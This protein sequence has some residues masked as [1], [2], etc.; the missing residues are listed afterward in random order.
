MIP[1]PE[2]EHIVEEVI[3]IIPKLGSYNI[4]DIGTGSGCLII[5]III[6]REKSYGTAV[7]ISK[8][9]INIAKHNAKIQNIQNRIKFINSN[10]DKF[11]QGKYDLI[12]SNPPYIK[13]CKINYLDDDVRLYE[14]KVALD[15]GV[16]GYSEIKKVIKKSSE[17]LKTKGKLVIEIDDKQKSFTNKILKK[18]GFYINKIVKDLAKKYRCIVSTKI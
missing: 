18:N 15:G 17:L 3:K 5:S 8:K 9:A 12:I 2:T 11:Y 6:E 7:D 1:R 14:P 10:I 4:L 13:N 16:D